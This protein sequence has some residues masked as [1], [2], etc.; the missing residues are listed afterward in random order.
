MRRLAIALALGLSACSGNSDDPAAI[1]A[2]YQADLHTASDQA[3]ARL[4]YFWE[5]FEAPQSDEYDFALK[6]ALPRRDGQPGKE[7]VWVENIARAEDHITGEL[8]V[9]PKHLGDLKK[10]AIVEFRE[11]DITD[12][13]MFR[14]QDL[15]GHYTTRV[16]LPRMDAEQAEVLR[17]ILAENPA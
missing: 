16:M 17:S 13:A 6:A 10:G 15:I 12:W 4:P 3:R 2:K 5:H 9:D 8:R 11:A 1:E 7:D 14:G